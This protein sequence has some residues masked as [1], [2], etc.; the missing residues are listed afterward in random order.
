M[1]FKLSSPAFTTGGDIPSRF[2]CDGDDVPP[3]LTWT[4]APAGTQ[5]FVL[6]MD[7]PD[8]PMGTFTHWVVFDIPAADQELR[9]HSKGEPVGVSGKN[10]MG[11]PGYMGPCPPAG[12]HRY[13]FRLYALD[14]PTLGL[15]AGASR[16]QV[17]HALK[18]HTVAVAELM[19]RY[20]RQ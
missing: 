4:G 13:F 16:E 8:A 19:G 6:I 2:T 15:R 14:V 18:G 20:S 11:K 1:T 7:D 12:T 9:S 3:P 5:S 17:E 10:S